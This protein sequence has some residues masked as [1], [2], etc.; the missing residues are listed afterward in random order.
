MLSKRISECGTEGG[1]DWVL[2]RQG[3]GRLWFSG[4]ALLVAGD[5]AV[6]VDVISRYLGEGK[7]NAQK[8]SGG[9]I[10]R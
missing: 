9:H 4:V 7:A 3:A 2:L 8:A 6:R 5:I 10:A 1:G